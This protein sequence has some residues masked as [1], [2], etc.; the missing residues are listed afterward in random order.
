MHGRT[1]DD[2]GQSIS[3]YEQAIA[4][5]PNYA[6]AHAA[7]AQVTYAYDW[8]WK[9]AEKEFQR[10]LELN[11]GYPSAHQWY[12]EY[13]W[14][15]GRPDEA[16]AQIQRAQELDPLSLVIQVSLGR[17]FYY[18]R[19][20]KRA[21][22][23]VRDSI[24]MKPDFFLGHLYLALACVQAGEQEEAAR[25]FQHAVQASGGSPLALAALAY[26]EAR[27]GRRTE[28]RG[29]LSRLRQSARS[30]HVPAIYFAGVYA[31]LGDKD[32]AFRWLDKAYEERSDYLIFLQ[33][34]PTFDPL[35]DDPRFQALVRR[36]KLPEPKAKKPT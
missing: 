23:E 16:Y 12:A 18:Q 21:I 17:H 3:F 31:G 1:P 27:A 5:D 8:D 34:E 33:I 29:L 25:E 4:A 10:A 9:T 28:A 2:L 19:D 35:R 13:L 22:K 36:L 11:S 26:A 24:E 30:R 14:A 6:L 32:Q 15:A 7:L 20:F